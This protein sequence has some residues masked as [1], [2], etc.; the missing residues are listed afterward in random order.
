M[1]VIK[2]LFAWQIWNSDLL[3]IISIIK[4]NDLLPFFVSAEKDGID[5]NFFEPRVVPAQ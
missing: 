1:K 2:S 5:P 4:C 3:L